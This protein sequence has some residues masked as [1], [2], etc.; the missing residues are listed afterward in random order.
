MDSVQFLR[1]ISIFSLDRI[2]LEGL[3][4]M[5]VEVKSQ[6]HATAP[7]RVG[8]SSKCPV[9]HFSSDSNKPVWHKCWLCKTSSHWPDQCLKFISLNTDDWISTAKVN[10]LCFSCLK[11]AGRGHTKDNCKRKQQ[12]TKLDNGTR[13][14]QH[15]HQLLHKSNPVRISVATTA[16]P[17]EAILPVVS[18]NIRSASSLFKCRNVLLDSGAQVSLIRQETAQT[19]HNH[20]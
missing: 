9:H 14:P 17:T 8:S 15:H 3:N 7:I 6:M 13:S 16:S 1:C 2:T 20:Y 4:W 12:C 19:L 18:A 11:R 5:N 10:H